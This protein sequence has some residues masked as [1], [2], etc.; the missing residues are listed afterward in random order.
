MGLSRFRSLIFWTFTLSF[1]AT[2]SLIIFYAFGYRYSQERGIFVYSGSITVNSLPQTVDIAIDGEAISP[3]Q[4]G[5]LNETIHI[6]GLMPGEHLLTVSAP[7][8]RP[9]SKKVTV[10][11]GVSSEY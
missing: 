4:Y 5:I 2:A 8:Y 11:S 6:A 9:W 1:F 7:G 10:Q 3:N